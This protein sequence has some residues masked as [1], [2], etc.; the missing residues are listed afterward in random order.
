MSFLRRIFINPPYTESAWTW[1]KRWLLKNP[2]K[3]INEISNVSQHYCIT[4][5]SFDHIINMDQDKALHFQFC[6]V[7]TIR[8]KRGK[9]WSETCHDHNL[10][11]HVRSKQL[12]LMYYFDRYWCKEHITSFICFVDQT[13]WDPL[14]LLWKVFQINNSRSRIIIVSINFI[15]NVEGKKS[16]FGIHKFE[17]LNHKSPFNKFFWTTLVVVPFMQPVLL[18]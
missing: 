18:L 17:K 16:S 14:L 13:F 7:F 10:F 9:K 6:D 12:S 4:H 15:N 5:F 1:H 8:R 11:W 3:L 2:T